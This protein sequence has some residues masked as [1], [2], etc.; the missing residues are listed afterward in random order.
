M[1]GARVYG[2]PRNVHHE[3]LQGEHY[4]HTKALR[5]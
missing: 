3:T 5:R 2:V 1:G 4:L